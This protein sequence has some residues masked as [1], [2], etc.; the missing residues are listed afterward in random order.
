M[1]ERLFEKEAHGVLKGM[2]LEWVCPSCAG[3]NFRLLSPDDR[4]G[5]EHHNHCRYCRTKYRVSYTPPAGPLEGE[6]G[7]MERLSDEHF[8]AE[9]KQELIRDYAEIEYMR[10]DNANPREVTGKQ[11]LLED[12]IIFF[13]RRRR[14]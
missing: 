3:V 10:A 9:E 13:K 14:I 4:L 12:K 11:R 5:G 7:F 8:T 2:T 6:A 1:F